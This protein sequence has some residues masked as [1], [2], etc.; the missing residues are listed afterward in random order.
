MKNGKIFIYLLAIAILYIIFLQV[1]GNKKIDVDARKIDKLKAKVEALSKVKDSL[2][3]ETLEL[4]YFDL[5][6][7][8]Y[9]QEYL[10]DQGFSVEQIE[11]LVLDTLISANSSEKDN[12]FVPLAGLE[13]T[14]KID[15]VKLI[16]HKWAVADF[17]DGTYWGQVLYLYEFTKERTLRLD[18]ITSHLY[19][20]TK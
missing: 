14:T 20:K 6:Y 19:A 16:N 1:N 15:R 5:R 17:T 8:E 7:D 11:A 18:V 12:P 4:S 9:A 2:E 13:G 3:N 10:E